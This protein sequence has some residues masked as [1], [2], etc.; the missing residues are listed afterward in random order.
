MDDAPKADME[1]SKRVHSNRE[2]KI[3]RE[4]N[5]HRKAMTQTVDWWRTGDAPTQALE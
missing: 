5:I 1:I 4:T 3:S 2:T